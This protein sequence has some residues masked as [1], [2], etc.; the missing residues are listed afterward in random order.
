VNYGSRSCP[1]LDR[2]IQ[3]ENLLQ[4]PSQLKYIF[5]ASD[6]LKSPP[7]TFVK[8]MVKKSEIEK[9]VIFSALEGAL[10]RALFRLSDSFSS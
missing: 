3:N 9:P 10:C 4:Q 6:L 2:R 5:P 8:K 1:K 7:N